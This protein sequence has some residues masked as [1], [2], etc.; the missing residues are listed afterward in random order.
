MTGTGSTRSRVAILLMVTSGGV[1]ALSWETLWQLHSALA[2]GVSAFGTAVTLAGAMA[3]MTLGALAMGRWLEAREVAHPL[4]I[5]GLLELVIGICGLLLAAAFRLLE[6]LDS[7]VYGLSPALA[8]YL[9]VAGILIVLGPPSAAMGATIPV[10]TLAGRAQGLSVAVLYACNTA[11]AALGVLAFAFFL[12]PHFGMSATG[13]IA[14]AINLGVFAL[15]MTLRV[16]ASPRSSP[17]RARPGPGPEPGLTLLRAGL[18]VFGSGF[19]TFGLEVAWFRS[20]R[21]AFASTTESFAIMLASVLVPLALAARLVP[22]LRARGWEMGGVV[23]LAGVAILLSTPLV[24]R[25]DLFAAGSERSYLVAL[26]R[27][28][29]LALS[30]IG[31]AMLCL[32]VVLPWCLEAFPRPAEVGRLY[33]LNTLGAVVGSLLAAWVLLPGFGFARTAWGLGVAV[34]AMALL[35][36]KPRLRWAGAVAAAAGLWVAMAN[37]SSIGRDRVQTIG[38]SEQYEIVAYREAPDST[39]SVIENSYGRRSLLIDGFVATSEFE[40]AAYMEWMGRLPMLLHEKPERALV[41]CFGTGQTAHAVRDEGPLRLDVVDVSSAVLKM[42]P[43]FTSNHSV[44]DDPRTHGVVMDGRA[45]IRRTG[46]SYDI[47]TLE[48]MPPFF[49]GVNALY[50]QRFYELVAEHLAPDGVV[51]QWL[52]MHLLAPFY[53]AS[54][55]A[56]F[57][58]V[59]PDAVLW[60]D[61]QGGTGILLG[62]LAG[63]AEPLASSWP[64]LSREADRALADEAIPRFV[65]LDPTSL[66][67]FGKRGEIITDDNQLLAYSLASGD[68]YA[69]GGGRTRRRNMRELMMAR[70]GY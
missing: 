47:V 31:P 52:P 36:S 8:P 29:A 49:A 62:R 63:N 39:I 70:R 37:T 24:E 57:Q 6:D 41:I 32:G 42:A 20:F 38:P 56:T 44:L 33:A 3:G 9:Q 60:L 48:P 22:W 14:A 16:A 13:R 40:S 59:F 64:G 25:M 50:S 5:Y 34:I 61:E 54:V 46:I 23:A 35:L 27:W 7:W 65:F 17:A 11:G 68:Y 55:A 58:S 1:A 19:V 67:R 18:L 10:F 66:A 15:A 12:L 21:S 2:L 69:E 26:L 30:S 43:Y 4:R 28:M 51:A 45:W 53:S